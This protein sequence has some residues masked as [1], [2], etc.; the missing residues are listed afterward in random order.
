ML[1]ISHFC[2]VT[3]IYNHFATCLLPLSLVLLL[4][5]L[6]EHF[7]PGRTVLQRKLRQCLAEMAN[8]HFF[9]SRG[10]VAQE[11]EELVEPVHDSAIHDLQNNDSLCTV[12]E[13]L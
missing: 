2:F 5:A 13:E 8:L 1:R 12:S 10:S 3:Y 11:E 9:G 7:V 4:L 6:L